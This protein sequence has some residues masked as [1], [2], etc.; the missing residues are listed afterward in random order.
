MGARA[1]SSERRQGARATRP[2]GVSFA[3]VERSAAD[4]LTAKRKANGIA[5]P[6]V[7]I[8]PSRGKGRGVFAARRIAAGEVIELAPVVVLP[9]REWAQLKKTKLA[10][11][12]FDWGRDNRD[13]SIVLGYGSLYNHS[14]RPNARFHHRLRE[15]V[16]EFVA[17]RQIR[18][19][20][21]IVVNYNG[22]P[23]DETPLWFQEKRKK[24]KR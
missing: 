22:D 6:P 14:H 15:R 24:R 10:D 8:G 21:E 11:Y 17:I 7:R 20:E 18:P 13:L 5:L 19:G 16:Y 1:D 2:P 3:A 4:A 23:D 9:A 12:A